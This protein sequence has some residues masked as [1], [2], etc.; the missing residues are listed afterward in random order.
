MRAHGPSAPAYVLLGLIRQA[1][2]NA[3]QA[4]HC[5]GRAVYLQPDHY[6]ALIHLP[7]LLEHRGET[8]VATVL[9]QRAQRARHNAR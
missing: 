6:E 8:A 4:E 1:A 3:A 2:G 9:R 7:L 5:F